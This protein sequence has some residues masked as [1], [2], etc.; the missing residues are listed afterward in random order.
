[1]RN[2]VWWVRVVHVFELSRRVHVVSRVDS[3][4]LHDAGGDVGDRGIEVNVCHERLVVAQT[5]ESGGDFAEVFCL[6]CAL[7]GESCV[8]CSGVKD[9]AT[10]FDAGFGVGGW[11][12]GHALQPQRF[13]ASEGTVA[14]HDAV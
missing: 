12:G 14:N 8:V 2:A 13:V 3:H 1:M 4:L 9:G 5:S 6:A 7:G 11:R 10:L